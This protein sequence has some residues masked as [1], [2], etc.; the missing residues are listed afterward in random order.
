MRIYWKRIIIG[1]LDFVLAGYLIVAVTSFNKPDVQG[2]VC[3][4][5]NIN[6]QDESTNGFISTQ[7][8]KNRLQAAHA[9]PIGKP[10]AYVN[11][12]KIEETLEQSPFV[13]KA[14]SYKTEGGDVYITVTQR[15]PVVRIKAE[16]G[17]DYYV[18][19]QNLIMPN[20][21]YTSDLVIATG[22]INRDFATRYI[23]NL[24]KAINSN[25]TWQNLVVQVNVQP[26]RSIEIV[27]RV[28]DF[29]VNIG[30]LPAYK[31]NEIREKAIKQY[32][33]KQF[34]R[35]QK[36]YRY[37]LSQ[38][39]WNRYSYIDLEFGNQIICKKRKH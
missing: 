8:V 29:I 13:N 1:T 10:L 36:F 3:K 6:I 18:D 26:D 33:D 21:H 28:G 5:V 25:P 27:P 15:L 11:L 14:E 2:K 31:N 39:G 7:E 16:N 37:G 32:V 19:D 17:D 34:T 24:A 20:S 30:H 4:R 35:L 12:R 38:A 23:A 9:Y 22:N